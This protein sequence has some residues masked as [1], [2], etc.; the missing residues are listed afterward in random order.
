MRAR[1]FR[2]H[3][4]HTKHFTL[5]V[6]RDVDK[7]VIPV[8]RCPIGQHPG[9]VGPKVFWIAV[10]RQ[11]KRRKPWKKFQHAF[12]VSRFRFDDSQNLPRLQ[13]YITRSD[14]IRGL[15]GGP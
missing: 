9:I 1:W 7:T 5:I 2:D 8:T 10:I 6:F 15:N 14:S 3:H 13:L 11:I 12:A 4:C